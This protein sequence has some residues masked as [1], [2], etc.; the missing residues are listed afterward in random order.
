ML[1][2][3]IKK[4]NSPVAAA[5][6]LRVMIG[7]DDLIDSVLA[8][9]TRILEQRIRIATQGA[10]YD[11]EVRLRLGTQDRPRMICSGRALKSTF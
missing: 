9:R 5:N 3:L 1:E 8:E 7:D 4:G 11:P 6:K 2:M 10:V